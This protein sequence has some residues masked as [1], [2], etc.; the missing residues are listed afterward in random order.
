M[1]VFFEE[2]KLVYPGELLA[3]GEYTA[4][5]N[6]FKHGKRVYASRIGLASVE[7]RKVSVIALRG[8]YDPQVGDVVVGEVVD[9]GSLNWSVDIGSP[10][11]GTLNASDVFGRRFDPERQALKDAFNVGD[12]VVAEVLAFDRTKNPLLTVVGPDLGK[13]TR[14]RIE[15]ITPAKI[16]R[17]IGKRGSMITLLRK[18]TGCQ[19]TIGKNGWVLVTGKTPGDEELAVQAIR[20]VEAQAHIPGL[21]DRVTGFL[22]NKGRQ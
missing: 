22:K 9:L 18:E 20:L 4:G 19:I 12:M 5:G 17:L 1:S 21:T 3:E 16:P 14:G 8:G 7:A 15:K 10:Y 6:T 13:V 11:I 2:R